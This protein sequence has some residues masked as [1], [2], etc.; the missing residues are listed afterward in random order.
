MAYFVYI[1]TVGSP[2]VDYIITDHVASPPSSVVG[3]TE[4]FLYLPASFFP[5]NQRVHFPAP[6][7][8]NGG[9]SI[10]EMRQQVRGSMPPLTPGLGLRG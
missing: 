4:K 2:T 7:Y 6:D 3:H 5:N 10:A 9:K 1:G 8:G